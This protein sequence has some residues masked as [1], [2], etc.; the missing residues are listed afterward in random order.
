[1]LEP[2]DED[3]GLAERFPLV[4]MGRRSHSAALAHIAFHVVTRL[5]P[6]SIVFRASNLL[7]CRCKT[8]VDECPILLDLNI[9]ALG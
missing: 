1:M 8:T 4:F 2:R 7:P 9:M 5:Q 6:R 3:D